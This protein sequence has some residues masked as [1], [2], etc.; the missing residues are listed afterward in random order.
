MHTIDARALDF[1][2]LN[3]QLREGGDACAIINCCGQRFIAAGM[4]GKSIT[5]DGV[6]GNA[7][8]AYL[9]GASVTVRGN[10][11]DAVG[12]TMNE[13]KIVIHGNIG[14]AAGYAM[15]GGKIFVRDN[16]G[17]RAGIH[18]KAY[19]E[20]SPLMVIGGTAGSFLGEYQAGGV[21]VVLGLNAGDRPIVGNFPCTGMHGGKLFLR[22]RCENI[23]FPGQVRVAPADGDALAEVERYVED[24]C[25]RFGY[26][27]A[28]VMDAPFTVVTP[29]S[30]NP[31]KQMYVAN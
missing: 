16:A 29:D 17:Y 23:R 19:R 18:M 30:K 5:I 10:V 15:R 22:G 6:P 12:D 7:L 9:N 11:Q 13:G 4:A 2:A 24:Y 26:D 27:K 20:K 21:I 14:D 1:Q 28:H 8:G 25:A 31:Y 3:Q